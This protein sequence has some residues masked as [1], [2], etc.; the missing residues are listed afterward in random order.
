MLPCR[1]VAVPPCR[2][3]AVLPCRRVAVTPCCR[4]ALSPCLR[5]ALLPARVRLSVDRPGHYTLRLALVFYHE[6]EKREDGV[7]LGIDDLVRVGSANRVPLL[8]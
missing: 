3:V 2:R 5:A 1:R 4:A 7:E 8:C 6:D